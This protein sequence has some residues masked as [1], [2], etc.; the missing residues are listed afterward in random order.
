MEAIS[1]ITWDLKHLYLWLI[2]EI[3]VWHSAQEPVKVIPT[4]NPIHPDQ[5]GRTEFKHDF[6]RALEELI[7]DISIESQIWLMLPRNWVQMFNIKNLNMN[8]ELQQSHI[9]WEIQQR[10]HGSLNEF[11]ILMPKDHSPSVLNVCTIN[12]HVFDLI[13]EITQS[14]GLNPHG[15]TVEPTDGEEYILDDEHNLLLAEPFHEQPQ[16]KADLPVKNIV[17]GGVVLSFAVIIVGGYMMTS[18]SGSAPGLKDLLGLKKPAAETSFELKM[19]ESAEL[20]TDDAIAD[21]ISDKII[22]S[23]IQTPQK[24]NSTIPGQPVSPLKKMVKLLPQGVRVELAVMSELD[25]KVELSGVTDQAGLIDRLKSEENLSSIKSVGK[26]TTPA[27]KVIVLRMQDHGWKP[28]TGPKNIGR[29]HQHATI[30]AMKANGRI[31][32]GN[33]DAALS[34]ADWTWNTPQ[35]FSKVYLAPE[36]D[37]WVV[38]V[39]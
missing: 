2:P 24:D 8:G 17:I 22:E 11:R 4:E 13:S 28:A 29:W 12:D 16:I 33:F 30:L 26:Y 5:L 20:Q 27:G 9:Y 25:F 23:A 38:T 18:R 39:Q 19:D 34:L 36:K 7:T 21:D 32:T 1:V 37:H 14:V 35:G 10:L 15:I 31:A 6:V 3:G